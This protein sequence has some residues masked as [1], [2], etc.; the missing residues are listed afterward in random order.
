[1]AFIMKMRTYLKSFLLEPTVLGLFVL[2][3]G[4]SYFRITLHESSRRF[5]EEFQRQNFVELSNAD[6][7]PLV[8]KLNALTATIPWVCIEAKSFGHV[9]FNLERGN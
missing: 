5:A 8:S 4:L 9:F 2:L 1:M 6:I 3:I 7:L